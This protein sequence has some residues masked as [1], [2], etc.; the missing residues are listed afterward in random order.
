MCAVQNENAEELVSSGMLVGEGDATSFQ[1]KFTGRNLSFWEY[2]SQNHR[3]DSPFVMENFCCHVGR[4]LFSRNDFNTLCNRVD[5]KHE[6]A[7]IGSTKDLFRINSLGKFS[8]QS[9]I[10]GWMDLLGPTSTTRMG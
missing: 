5:N 10:C 9:S 3:V 2:P 7:N 8:S 6:K 1:T 4:N